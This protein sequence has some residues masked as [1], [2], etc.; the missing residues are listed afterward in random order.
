MSLFAREIKKLPAKGEECLCYFKMLFPAN[1][2]PSLFDSNFVVT[3]DI[4]LSGITFCT[5][6]P[7]IGKRTCVARLI[8][9]FF[10][11]CWTT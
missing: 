6:P 8:A 2:A 1:T 5:I 7:I 10:R 3:I 11:I 4:C 9:S